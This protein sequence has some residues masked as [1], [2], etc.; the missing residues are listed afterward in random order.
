MSRKHR[1]IGSF[2][3]ADSH[4]LVRDGAFFNQCKNV[5]R[6]REGQEI[7]LGDGKG[8][9][10]RAKILAYGTRSVSVELLDRATV[11]R[12]VPIEATLYA[13]MLKHEHFEFV[14]QKATEA[15]IA[16]IVP[17]E[18]ARTV[19]KGMKRARLETIM[20]EA[21]EQSGRA[22]TPVLEDMMTF[23]EAL[24]AAKAAGRVVFFDSSG[25]A[26]TDIPTAKKGTSIALFVGPEG[27]WDAQE[28]AGAHDAGCVIA[29]LG[30]LVLRAETAATIAVYLG[31]HGLL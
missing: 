31:A 16:R 21:S 3:L 7:V 22:H 8:S 25:I 18:S 4:L 20:R 15:G 11:T 30:G 27:G 19:K 13:S 9:E 23:G 5:L 1:F 14:V 28:L 29:S 12:E 6:L 10:A 17:I 26:L 24:D 2:N